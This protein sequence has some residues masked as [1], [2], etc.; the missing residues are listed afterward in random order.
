M[1]I[2]D[3]A[4]HLFTW[5]EQATILEPDRLKTV[6]AEALGAAGRALERA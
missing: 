6:M 1:C 5:G 4:W 3:R 2:R